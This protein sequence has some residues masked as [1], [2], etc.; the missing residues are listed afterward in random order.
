MRVVEFP[1]GRCKYNNKR[2]TDSTC[3]CLLVLPFATRETHSLTLPSDTDERVSLL[4]RSF[5]TSLTARIL[6]AT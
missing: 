6:Q 4:D 3:K 5:R 1:F 2:K